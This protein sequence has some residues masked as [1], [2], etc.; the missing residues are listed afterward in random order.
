MA[1]VDWSF[2]RALLD[3]GWDRHLDHAAIARRLR[4]RRYLGESCTVGARSPKSRATAGEWRPTHEPI[5]DRATWDAA[6]EALG[7]RRMGGRPVTGESRVAGFLLRSMAVCGACGARLRSQA[8]MPGSSTRH[9]GWYVC[10]ACGVHARQDAA[11]ARAG[12]LVLE[13]LDRERERLR[14]PPA[15]TP[16]APDL[17]AERARLVARLDRLLDAIADG[18]VSRE[19]AGAKVAETE[20][21]IADVDARRAAADPPR[22]PARADL[23]VAVDGLRLAWEGL[24]TDERRAALRGLATQA[25][26]TRKGAKWARGAWEIEI[27]WRES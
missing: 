16:K 15:P 2:I 12:E 25:T 4:D 5:V 3:R 14:R 1:P 9:A 27:C 6:Q 21:A 24:T 10:L 20:R 7:G 11:D 18:T 17:A 23:L 22:A 26:I 19:R 8:P 13:R